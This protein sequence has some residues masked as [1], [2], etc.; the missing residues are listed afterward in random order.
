[1]WTLVRRKRLPL[2]GTML[3]V[4]LLVV[5]MLS[6]AATGHGSR[7][8]AAFQANRPVVLIVAPAA[9]RA[10]R[11]LEAYAD[12]VAY[13]DGFLHK[14]PHSLQ[15]LQLSPAEYRAELNQPRLQHDFATLFI[16]NGVSALVYQG[17]I[18]EPQVYQFG[19]QYLQGGQVSHDAASYGLKEQRLHC[20]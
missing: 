10:L 13:R 18:L 12:W 3:A 20:R 8:A 2:I 19:M 7:L 11:E 16:R 1:M 5:L 14:A 15:V 4:P 9:G 17:M 6:T